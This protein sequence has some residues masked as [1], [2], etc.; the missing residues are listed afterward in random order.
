MAPIAYRCT[1]VLMMITLLSCNSRQRLDDPSLSQ[2]LISNQDSPP[3]DFIVDGG[4]H[5]VSINVSDHS[6]TKLEAPPFPQGTVLEVLECKNTCDRRYI[7]THNHV[8]SSPLAHFSSV[9]IRSCQETKDTDFV[10]GSFKEMDI[11]AD[12]AT[13]DS[14]LYKMLDRQ[15]KI[16]SLIL[17]QVINLKKKSA[18]IRKFW[19]RCD[20]DDVKKDQ[21]VLL[22]KK[23]ADNIS[24]RRVAQLFEA[25]IAQGDLSILQSKRLVDTNERDNDFSGREIFEEVLLGVLTAGSLAGA[26]GTFHGIYQWYDFTSKQRVIKSGKNIYRLERVKAT[27]R[28]AHFTIKPQSNGNP[29]FEFLEDPFTR[30]IYVIDT[31]TSTAGF[32]TLND[33]DVKSIDMDGYTM[34]ADGSITQNAALPLGKK[35]YPSRQG[36]HLGEKVTV[37][38][39][40]KNPFSQKQY[41]ES[42]PRHRY[43]PLGGTARVGEFEGLVKIAGKASLAVAAALISGIFFIDELNLVEEQGCLELREEIKS[44]NGYRIKLKHALSELEDLKLRIAVII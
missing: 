14:D 40:L 9:S 3:L 43:D 8:F 35:I 7:T 38:G 25:V 12:P 31:G 37:A 30:Q 22:V 28:Q 18:A 5:L 2:N 24:D 10:C 39:E 26:I 42:I 23:L 27:P 15:E 17:S 41:L 16:E 4:I 6:A 29:N 32:T 34:M 33:A 19:N 1:L 11:A 21:S 36:D 44:F 20:L 13:V